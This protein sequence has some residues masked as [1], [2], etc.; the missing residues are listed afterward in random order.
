MVA[1][2]AA[3]WKSESERQSELKSKISFNY[4]ARAAAAAAVAAAS[5]ATTT[6]TTSSAA[7]LPLLLLLLASLGNG[8]KDERWRQHFDAAK[9]KATDCLHNSGL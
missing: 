7:V 9:I 3:E 4:A 1:E 5:S 2:A 8:G 6:R